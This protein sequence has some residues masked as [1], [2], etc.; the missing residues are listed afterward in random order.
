VASG[1]TASVIEK[2]KL[3][4]EKKQSSTALYEKELTKLD[5]EETR[6]LKALRSGLFTMAKV[7]VE[8]KKIKTRRD[9]LNQKLKEISNRQYDVDTD[10]LEAICKRLTN[11][12]NILSPEEK[13]AIFRT[14]IESVIYN[15]K[16]RE[17]KLNFILPLSSCS[18]AT[19]L[20]S[21]RQPA[22]TQI[23][24]KYT[25]PP[26]TNQN[27]KDWQR[28]TGIFENYIFPYL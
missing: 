28:L 26:C 22:T 11:V 14:L 18:V 21:H 10:S 4:K 17:L 2:Y 23:E 24:L 12:I 8:M 16:T 25:I 20:K 13:A 15:F 6:M 27:S 5:K 9:V 19:T 3:S 7:K 1:N